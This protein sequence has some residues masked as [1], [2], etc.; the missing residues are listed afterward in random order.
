MNQF[1]RASK[2]KGRDI[3]SLSF[4][5]SF[6]LFLLLHY[7]ALFIKLQIFLYQQDIQNEQIKQFC[8]WYINRD[9]KMKERQ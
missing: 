6:F 2:Q 1:L 4:L 7:T 9:N 3:A 5:L 8:F